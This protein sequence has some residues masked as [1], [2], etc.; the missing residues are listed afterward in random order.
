MS[1]VISAFMSSLATIA[2]CGA[3]PAG[4][5][6]LHHLRDDLGGRHALALGHRGAAFVS[7][8]WSTDEGRLAVRPATRVDP[9]T[10]WRA[11]L[12]LPATVVPFL[13][14]TQ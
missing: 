3:Q 1:V 2:N 12:P 9:S 14:S 8:R 10:F 6:G 4:V 11:A 5:L 13:K 7:R